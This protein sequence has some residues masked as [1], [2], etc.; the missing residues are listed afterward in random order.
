MSAVQAVID[1]PELLETILLHVDGWKTLFPLIRVS[2]YFK[3]IIEDSIQLQRKMWLITLRPQAS[4]YETSQIRSN[5]RF[6]FNSGT[7]PR[8]RFPCRTDNSREWLLDKCGKNKGRSR[9]GV[10]IEVHIR[11]RKQNQSVSLDA[12]QGDGSWRRTVCCSAGELRVTLRARGF[13]C[14]MQERI[15]DMRR[16]ATLQELLVTVQRELN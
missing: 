10:Y 9:H 16:G 3:S 2:R 12:L 7:F 14:H 15:F 13:S 11:R 8:L 4:S 1:L 5:N 6:L